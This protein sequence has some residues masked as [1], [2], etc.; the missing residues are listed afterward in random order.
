MYCG[1]H[2]NYIYVDTIQNTHNTP[3]LITLVSKIGPTENR[4]RYFIPRGAH[5][6]NQWARHRN[7]FIN[8]KLK[9]ECH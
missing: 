1:Y 5:I 6:V 9:M 8:D 4:T 3:N 2:R 7:I